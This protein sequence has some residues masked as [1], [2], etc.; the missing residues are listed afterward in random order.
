MQ[1]DF[2]TMN[3]QKSCQKAKTK[4][5]EVYMI[6]KLNDEISGPRYIT[7]G[8]LAK[9]YHENKIRPSTKNNKIMVEY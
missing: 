3:K 2:N 8:E 9:L 4:K 1:E 5:I 7:G 6:D